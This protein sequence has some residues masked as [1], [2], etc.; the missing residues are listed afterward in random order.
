MGRV[1]GFRSALL[2]GFGPLLVDGF[3][4]GEAAWLVGGG[5]RVCWG[6]WGGVV[7]VVGVGGLGEGAVWLW[8]G[9]CG[10]VWRGCS[11]GLVWLVWAGAKASTD[12]DG[13]VAGVEGVSEVVWLPPH[14]GGGG[15]LDELLHFAGVRRR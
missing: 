9:V 10:V 11:A 1:L 12:V 4:I 5:G 14:D 6:R 3:A 8:G 13:A 7:F 2:A 15:L